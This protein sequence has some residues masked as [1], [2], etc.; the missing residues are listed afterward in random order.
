[1]KPRVAL[2]L[3]VF[4]LAAL[5]LVAGCGKSKPQQEAG[6]SQQAAPPAQHMEADEGGQHAEGG[7]AKEHEE[8]GEAITPAATSAGIWEQIAAEQKKLETAI[9][10]G[11]LADVH[12]LAFGI[13]DLGVALAGKATGL[14]AVNAA[15]LQ[16]TVEHMKQSAA[17]LDEY[18]DAG[19]LGGVKEEYAR[20]Q[21]QLQSLKGL[22]G[23]A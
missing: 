10:S 3:V 1:M 20:F 11:Q 4:V 23:G 14:A 21:Q 15:K 18:G 5:A 22:T 6:G 9:Q 17:K 12:H 16:E 19:N 2:I 8:A 7:E 13:R